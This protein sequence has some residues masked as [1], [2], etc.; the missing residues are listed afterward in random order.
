MK[1]CDY[2]VEVRRE[3]LEDCRKDVFK[4]LT[5]LEKQQKDLGRTDT[6]TFY[7]E[8]LRNLKVNGVANADDETA[9]MVRELV[10]CVKAKRPFPAMP[11]TKDD[12][13][14]KDASSEEDDDDEVDEDEDE[15]GVKKKAKGKKAPSKDEDESSKIWT[16]RT[17]THTLRAY[18]RELVG[19]VRSARY[20]EAVRD[21]QRENVHLK[22]DCPNCKRTVERNSISLLSKCGHMGCES[23]VRSA[24]LEGKCVKG[25]E[26]CDPSGL[27]EGHIVSAATLGTDDVVKDAKREFGKKL[28]E[29]VR[30]I[31]YVSPRLC[32]P[33]R[34]V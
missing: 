31:K 17:N 30:L 9:A 24:A 23:C 19:R 8:W 22:I 34:I 14:K 25:R 15:D 26:M 3:E 13:G 1:A 33:N 20:F 2:V 7:Q 5:K 11:V 10:E 4:Q 32:L 28:E 16:I 18:V 6:E 21:I 29:V 12:N 27:T